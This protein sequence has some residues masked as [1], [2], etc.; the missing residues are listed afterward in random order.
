MTSSANVRSVY[1]Q[2]NSRGHDG[3][4]SLQVLGM[5]RAANSFISSN[6]CIQGIFPLFPVV[7]A[8]CFPDLVQVNSSDKYWY[9]YQVVVAVGESLF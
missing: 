3:S 7:G 4:S 1:D 6:D 5:R 2:S 8:N 9:P